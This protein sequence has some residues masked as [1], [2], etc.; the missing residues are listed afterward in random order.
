MVTERRLPA[1]LERWEAVQQVAAFSRRQW[2]VAGWS[3]LAALLIGRPRRAHPVVE[4]RHARPVAT[5]DRTHC[6]DLR[7]ARPAQEGP[8][9]GQNRNRCGRGCWHP[10]DGLPR[11]QPARDPDLRGGRRAVI[12]RA[13]PGPHCAAIDRAAR[14]HPADPAAHDADLPARPASRALIGL[15]PLIPVPTLLAR[16]DQQP[17]FRALRQRAARA[18]QGRPRPAWSTWAMAAVMAMAVRAP[19]AWPFSK[20]SPLTAIV[21]VTWAR[22]STSQPRAAA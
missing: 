3:Y 11:M 18:R 21:L 17:G 5:A 2:K 1:T 12:P 4:L 15:A 19:L 7:P 9:L 13:L 20:S 14:R 8:P 6:R 16:R 10:C 22:H